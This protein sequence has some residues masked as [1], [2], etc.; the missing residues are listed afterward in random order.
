MKKIAKT[1]ALVA[2]VALIVIGVLAFL[3]MGIVG[4]GGMMIRYAGTPYIHIVSGVLLLIASTMGE[5]WA[6]FGLYMVA[7]L[8]ALICGVGYASQDRVGTA[9]LFDVLRL[10]RAD[11]VFHG[12]LAVT[13]AIFGKMNTARQQLIWD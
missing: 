7:A 4:P 9:N 1:L 10:T 3:P 5:S 13:L 11:L 2:G 6:A 12:V 8:Q